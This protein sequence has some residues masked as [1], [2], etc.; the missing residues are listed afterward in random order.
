M[1]AVCCLY[2]CA[3][4]SATPCRINQHADTWRYVQPFSC[5]PVSSFPAVLLSIDKWQIKSLC[6]SIYMMRSGLVST[7]YF[8]Q[9]Y[10]VNC[11]GYLVRM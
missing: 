7:F 10:S 9:H 8:T 1:W 6:H 5:T 4:Q 3:T 2:K 11:S